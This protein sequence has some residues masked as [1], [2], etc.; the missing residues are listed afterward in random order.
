MSASGKAQEETVA[1]Q[2]HLPHHRMDYLMCNPS[3]LGYELVSRCYE[4]GWRPDQISS[5]A[6]TRNNR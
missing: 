6:R 5:M 2:D 1:R 3:P 4:M